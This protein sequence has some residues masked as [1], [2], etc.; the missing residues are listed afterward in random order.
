ML[1]LIV[2]FVAVLVIG[3][4]LGKLYQKGPSV[5]AI[6][7]EWYLL[8]LIWCYSFTLM[9]V[10]FV[11]CAVAVD[12]FQIM[13]VFGALQMQ[14]PGPI[15][16]MFKTASAS[17]SNTEVASPECSVSVGYV[18]KWYFFQALP[19]GL[20]FIGFLGGMVIAGY[21]MVRHPARRQ[22]PGY[23]TKHMAGMY[24]SF[25]LLLNFMYI[26]LTKKG[27]EA[28]DCTLVGFDRV[29]AAD[30]TVPCTGS[31]YTTLKFWGESR[32]FALVMWLC[33]T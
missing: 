11:F 30:A 2:I 31:T 6:G 23:L 22:E 5:A 28:L 13:S 24:G 21:K 4:I 17:T 32:V 15:T 8:W 3:V 1:E 10:L 9:Y 7:S 16:T 33:D 25:L 26:S 27:F 19:L 20:I 29:L 14:W 12:Y 18:D